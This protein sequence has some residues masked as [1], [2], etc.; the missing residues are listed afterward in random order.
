MPD[1]YPQYARSAVRRI[2]LLAL[3]VAVAPCVAFGQAPAPEVQA[4]N[5]APINVVDIEA[6]YRIGLRS[7]VKDEGYYRL[8]LLGSPVSNAGTPPRYAKHIDLTAPAQTT[9][10]GD[11]NGLALRFEKNTTTVGGGLFEAIGIQPL[12]LAGLR[13]VG[14]RGTAF[15]GT[16]AD[17]NALQFAAGLETKT[18]RVPGF[19]RTQ[20]TNWMVFGLNAQHQ[21]V[22][23]S[24]TN[25]GNLGLVTYRAFLGKSFGWQKNPAD[26]VAVANHVADLI[27]EQAP[28]LEAA[29]TLATTIN[30]IPA[31]QRSATQQLLLD[32]IGENPT[33][34]Q[35][36]QT[37]RDIVQG[38]SEAV[39]QMPTLSLYGEASGWYAFSGAFASGQ[40]RVRSLLT[41][42]LEYW[43]IPRRQDI[44][45]R[46]RYENGFE[47][48]SP[49]VR[50]DQLLAAIALKL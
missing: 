20:W 26:A 48:A 23:D 46:L 8:A 36:T 47:Q 1:R 33:A 28:N 18:Y 37:V 45:L 35:W 42:T 32:A 25:D 30:A 13:A 34:A 7:G 15:V 50:K 5:P 12:T 38:D 6:G 19:G 2:P 27:L 11:R 44:F 22:T 9:G 39:V 16:D 43:F 31:N 3:F 41:V 40:N 4:Q 24:E 21:E 14:L 17:F 10:T 29:N 49:T